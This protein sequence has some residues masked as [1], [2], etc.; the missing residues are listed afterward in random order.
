MS[1]IDT[2]YINIVSGSLNKFSWKNSKVATCRCPVCGDSEKNPNKKRF[3]FYEAKSRYFVKCHNCGYSSTFEQFLKSYYDSVYKEYKTE[4]LFIKMSSQPEDTEKVEK[5]CTLPKELKFCVRA[6]KLENG[7]LCLE[8][9]KSRKI[10]EE[11]Y[12]RL[13]YTDSFKSV[14]SQI[15]E[16][17][18]LAKDDCRLV[19]PF[20]DKNGNIFA[21]Q[22]RSLSK[23]SNS[24]RYITAKNKS[25]NE[26]FYGI[27]K[28][29]YSKTLYIVE[30][31]LDSLFL[32]NAIAIA[33]SSVSDEYLPNHDDIVFV[34][35][36]EK[37]NK[38]IVKKINSCIVKKFKVCI[39]PEEIEQKD[40]ND[41][42][43]SGIDVKRV[44]KENTLAGLTA[45]LRFNKWK[46]V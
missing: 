36:N 11:K 5:S 2:K 35:D 16:T 43:L 31:P 10:P 42:V 9:L 30:G 12:D 3:Y 32:D 8:Y 22:G 19:I 23:D 38:E 29:D 18:E 33:G 26:R 20:F 1:Y 4:N 17:K 21:A 44:I 41:M 24:I 45:E 46:K 14:V 40:I 6:D 28:I 34:Y 37:R 15:D 39:W 25:S 27:D 7:H 13:Y